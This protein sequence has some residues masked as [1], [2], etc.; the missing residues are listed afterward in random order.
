MRG[1]IITAQI[2][3]SVKSS[4]EINR[5]DY[6]ICADGGWNY[7]K[8]EKIT[9]HCIIG[10]FDSTVDTFENIAAYSRS[11]KIELIKAS[12]EKDDTDTMLAIKKAIATN[13]KEILIIGGLGGR[14]DHT[15]GNLA[16]L[17]FLADQGIPSEIR[18][19]DTK[20]LISDDNEIIL[21]YQEASYFSLLSY[22]ESCEEVSI[23][24]AKYNTNKLTLKNAYPIGVSNE[25]ID[26]DVKIS[27]KSGRLIISI[28]K[29]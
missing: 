18:D 17:A 5:N 3:T 16:A 4:V 20:L 6:I 25:F 2:N 24:N 12:P 27:K 9:P 8:E 7:I 10:D 21:P 29:N 26:K 22:S 15:L 19:G 11:Q 13:C 23:Y 14:I 28:I 1:I